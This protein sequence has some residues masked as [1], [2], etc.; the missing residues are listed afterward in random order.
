MSNSDELNRIE[1]DHSGKPGHWRLSDGGGEVLAIP[2]NAEGA[3]ALFDAFTALPG[4]RAS[5]IVEATRGRPGTVQTVW[6]RPGTR[7]A[8][9][10]PAIA[11][12][13]D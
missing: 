4:M 7:P 12:A 2:M 13:D 5:R 11:P 10:G 9:A 6:V 8:P 3:D 1:I